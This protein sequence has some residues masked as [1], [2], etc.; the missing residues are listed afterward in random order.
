MIIQKHTCVKRDTKCSNELTLNMFYSFA[1]LRLFNYVTTF[2]QKVNISRD[3]VRTRTHRY[4]YAG[5][6]KSTE[7]RLPVDSTLKLYSHLIFDRLH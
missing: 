5:T 6:A 1:G 7:N 2:S 3:A 4:I